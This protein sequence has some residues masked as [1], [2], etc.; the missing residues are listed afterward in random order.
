MLN[1]YTANRIS[2][3]QYE[4][5]ANSQSEILNA[6]FL[7]LFAVPVYFLVQTLIV[8]RK[9][10]SKCRYCFQLSNPVFFCLLLYLKKNVQELSRKFVYSKW[11]A[12]KLSV[13][14]PD[15]SLLIRKVCTVLIES[16][17]QFAEHRT[18]YPTIMGLNPISATKLL[19]SW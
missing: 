3:S 7:V 16:V 2:Q 12:Q 11:K 19:R 14:R 15:L 5:G 18:T 13:L 6:Q 10:N 8:K 4:C 1:I 9:L 17:L